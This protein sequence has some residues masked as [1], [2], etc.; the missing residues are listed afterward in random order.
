MKLRVLEICKGKGITAK[1]LAGILGIS[2]VGLSQQM[3]GNPTI[4]TLERIATALGVPI[5]D[6]FEQ[7]ATDA[8]SCP[9]CGGKIRTSKV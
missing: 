8:I 2:P 9:Y 4:E 1:D 5:A 6:L 3:N 7:P